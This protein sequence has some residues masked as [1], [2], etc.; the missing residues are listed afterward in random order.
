MKTFPYHS[1]IHLYTKY[2]VLSDST[3]FYT[4]SHLLV[5]PL[6]IYLLSS[7]IYLV[8]RGSKQTHREQLE[9]VCIYINSP[10]VR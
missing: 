4:S 1:P 7:F 9:E 5:L 3:L 8:A 6:A 10:G 2:Y